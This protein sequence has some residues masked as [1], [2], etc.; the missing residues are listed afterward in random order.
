MAST[1]LPGS[2]SHLVTAAVTSKTLVPS[3]ATV[4]GNSWPPRPAVLAGK[5]AVRSCMA[6]SIWSAD[7]TWL[8]TA[9]PE[10]MAAMSWPVAAPSFTTSLAVMPAVSWPGTAH[11]TVYSP[12]GRVLM[13][14]GADCLGA[15]SGVASFLSLTV[16]LW[17]TDPVLVTV[18]VDPVVVWMVAGLTLNSERV[19]VTGALAAGA[20]AFTE[21]LPALSTARAESPVANTAQ[22]TAMHERTKAIT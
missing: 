21:V 8:A 9:G 10:P 1:D 5:A 12:A 16:R 15:R 7:I 18:M 11:I 3:G 14:S 2:T 19:T 4:G 22:N 13:S 20:A 6:L 17:A